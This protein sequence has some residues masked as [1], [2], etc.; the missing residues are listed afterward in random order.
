MGD[1]Y[2]EKRLELSLSGRRV[3]NNHRA[4]KKLGDERNELRENLGERG[5]LE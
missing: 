1:S 2:R 5:R 4:A 3:R